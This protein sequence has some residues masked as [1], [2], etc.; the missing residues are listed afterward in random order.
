MTYREKKFVLWLGNAK[1]CSADFN[2]FIK[3]GIV[4]KIE[5][6][7]SWKRRHLDKANHNLDFA[8]FIIM[9]SDKLLLLWK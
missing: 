7:V 3:K 5:D 6:G 4:I 8:S 9:H 2:N 1:I